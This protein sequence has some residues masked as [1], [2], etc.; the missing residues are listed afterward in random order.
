MKL[1]E[2][3]QAVE[4]LIERSIDPET[5]L[6]TNE[7]FEIEMTELDYQLEAKALDVATY[8]RGV[9]AEADVYDTEIK[10]LQGKKKALTNKSDRLR[11]YLR[12]NL[13]DDFRAK[14]HRVSVFYQASESVEIDID[15]IN[16]PDDMI[17]VKYEPD[18]VALKKVLNEG[19]VIDGVRLVTNQNL[20][21]RG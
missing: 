15:T 18:K 20:Q 17:R 10:R 12:S 8:I 14:D 19:R 9:E 7:A 3:N 2:M 1:Y 13:P 16:L 6:V 11:D 21:I 4:S 5:G